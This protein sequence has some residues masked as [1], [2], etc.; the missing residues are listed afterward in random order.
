MPINSII[1]FVLLIYHIES[2]PLIDQGTM[3][4][5]NEYYLKNESTFYVLYRTNITLRCEYERIKR[6]PTSIQKFF[7]VDDEGMEVKI[8]SVFSHF[9]S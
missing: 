7:W 2:I 5:L 4:E 8:F 3:K 6:R 1:V 9:Q